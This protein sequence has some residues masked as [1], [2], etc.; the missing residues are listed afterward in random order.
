MSW[1][2]QL[3]IAIGATIIVGLLFYWLQ[4]RHLRSAKR[5]RLTRAQEEVI[6]IVELYII[7]EQEIFQDT[8]SRLIKASSRAHNVD[9]EAIYSPINIIEDVE[10]R[11]QRS[12]HLDPSEKETYEK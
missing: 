9:L 12:R 10:L 3:L 5:E 8:V 11:L 4:L 6:D 2:Y 7:N 1:P